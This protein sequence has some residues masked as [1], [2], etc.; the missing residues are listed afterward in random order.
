[1]ITDLNTTAVRKGETCVEVNRKRN[2]G[3]ELLQ[4]SFITC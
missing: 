3:L 4:E 1:M 2:N